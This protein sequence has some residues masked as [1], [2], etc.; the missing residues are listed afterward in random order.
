MSKPEQ[1]QPLLFIGIDW[2]DQEHA[3]WW[4]TDDRSAKRSESI[5]QEPQAIADWIDSLQKRFPEHRILI[6]LEQSRGA[7]FVGLAEFPQLE[8]YP[9]N[10]KQLAR[11]RESI[12][13]S[14]GKTDP[15][16]ARL[17]AEFLQHARAR[18]RPWR[19]DDANTRQ[20][21]ELVELRRKLVEQRKRLV[22]QLSGSLK[23]YFPQAEEG[24]PRE[25]HH[26]LMVDLL[27]RWPTLQQLKRVHPKTLRRFLAEHGMRNT[28]QQTQWIEAMRSA[29]PLT[30][31]KALIEPRSLFVVNL[32][33]QIRDLNQAIA[34]FE[35]QLNELTARHDDA[36]TFRSLPGAGQAMTPRLIAAFGSDRERY[37][38]AEQVQCASGIAPITARSGKS[39]VVQKRFAC[40][41]FLRQTF[42]EFAEHARRWSDWSR[43][44][45][46]MKRAQGMKHQAAVR[47]LAYKWIRIAFRLWQDR[48]TYSEEAY[49]EQLKKHHS[50]IV[51]Y[52]PPERIQLQTT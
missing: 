19:P 10:P 3:A 8:L 32:V 27:R 43:A 20:I 38:S 12:Y 51:K 17:L 18:L 2:A 1:P 52:L 13:P 42:H 26:P 41:T 4:I 48:T 39:N 34:Q 15:G 45:Y 36:P 16:D 25:L 22:S 50:P 23:L 11:Y 49:I 30:T 9:I 5:K 31:D 6:A 29:R 24:A 7:L 28:E 44:F 35:E 46:E 33:Q 47:A 14:G 37:E 21:G 40:T